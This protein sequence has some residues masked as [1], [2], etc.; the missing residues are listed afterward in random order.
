MIPLGKNSGET[1]RRQHGDRRRIALCHDVK[2]IVYRRVLADRGDGAR[3]KRASTDFAV[4]SG[5]RGCCASGIAWR[6]AST[7]VF[8]RPFL[9]GN[10]NMVCLDN[11]RRL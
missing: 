3:P 9:R 6:A 10:P 4:G 11:L 2:R 5:T 8:S 7:V 1:G